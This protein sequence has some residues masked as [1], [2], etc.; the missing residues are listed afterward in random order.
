MFKSTVHFMKLTWALPMIALMVAAPAGARLTETAK[1]RYDT[2]EGD[3]RW[4]ETDVSFLTGNE[5][6]D[7][8]GSI[9]FNILKTYATIFF[10]RDDAGNAKIAVIRIDSPYMVCGFKFDAG[11]LPTYSKM[12]GPDQEGRV[13]EICTLTYC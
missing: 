11:C 4:Q 3:S 6:N 8:T 13:W 5:L 2:S 7:L 9:R 1:V 12:K 10:G